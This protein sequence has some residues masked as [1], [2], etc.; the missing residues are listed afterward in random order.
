MSLPAVLERVWAGAVYRTAAV[1]ATISAPAAVHA[2]GW[3]KKQ[4]RFPIVQNPISAINLH[5]L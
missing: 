4:K 1:L 3:S 5:R 2:A